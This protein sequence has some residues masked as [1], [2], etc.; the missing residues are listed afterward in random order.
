[1]HIFINKLSSFFLVARKRG[2]KGGERKGERKKE[3]EINR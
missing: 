3:R 1:L 2:G